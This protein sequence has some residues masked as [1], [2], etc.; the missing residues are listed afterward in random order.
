MKLI[1]QPNGKYCS[2]DAYGR[3]YFVNCTEQEVINKYIEDAKKDM[4]KAEHF[5]EIVSCI[6]SGKL[7]KAERVITD[8]VLKSMG[9]DKT[10]EELSKFIELRP[11][12]QSYSPCD[13]TTYGRCPTCKELVQDGMGHTDKKCKH[14]GQMLKW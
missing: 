3:A 7:L 4:E 6:T 14:C 9:F 10:Y 8:E 2:L 12:N 13:F 11:I 5:G 1:K